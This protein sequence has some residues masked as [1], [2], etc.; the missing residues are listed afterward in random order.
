MLYMHYTYIHT[1]IYRERERERERERGGNA[2]GG[3][4]LQRGGGGARKCFR[5]GF[6]KMTPK[7]GLFTDTRNVPTCTTQ[8][9]EPYANG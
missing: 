4:W 9:M 2:G 7:L 1:Y 5:K 8:T 3:R 6:I